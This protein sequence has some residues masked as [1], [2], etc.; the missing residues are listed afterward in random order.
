MLESVKLLKSY[1]A[2]L[3]NFG[4]KDSVTSYPVYLVSGPLPNE[5]EMHKSQLTLF[6][7]I[8]CQYCVRREVASERLTR[9]S[10]LRMSIQICLFPN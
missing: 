10:G 5:T 9:I 8:L 6:G 1:I 4:Q 7:N 2:K 3:D